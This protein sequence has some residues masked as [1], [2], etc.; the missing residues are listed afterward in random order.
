MNLRQHY[1]IKLEMDEEARAESRIE[2]R[3]RVRRVIWKMF[4]VIRTSY[5]KKFSKKE[6]EKCKEI[7]HLV[8]YIVYIKLF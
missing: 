4:E 1:A 3:I 7:M 5:N 8:Y 2:G 6:F